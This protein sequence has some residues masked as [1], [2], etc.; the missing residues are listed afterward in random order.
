MTGYIYLIRNKINNKLYIGQTIGNVRQ[1]WANH[2]NPKNR[3]VVSKA[4]TKYG[5][6]NFQISVIEKI[7]EEN[8]DSLFDK[9]NMLEKSY[10]QSWNCLV[11]SGY[12]VEIGGK[13][14]PMPEST[15]LKIS[16]ALKGQPTRK[17]NLG[18]KFS[19]EHKEKM[20]KSSKWSRPVMCLENQ[21][22][23]LSITHAAKELNIPR[24]SLSQSLRK[25]G[26]YE[27]SVTVKY[28]RN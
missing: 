8:R 7:F 21:T 19:E 2:C 26:I 20:S 25:T 15:K 5:K 13:N 1:R 12:N 6:I 4:I 23:Y 3:N 18:K 24:T 10:I 14:A 17:S 27:G 11:P 28:A 22:V 16:K 9:L